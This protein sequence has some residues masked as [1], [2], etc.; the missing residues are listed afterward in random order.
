MFDRILDKLGIEPMRNHVALVCRALLAGGLGE[1][2]FA[3]F[4][5]LSG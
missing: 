4:R 1:T 3:F 5:E 2:G